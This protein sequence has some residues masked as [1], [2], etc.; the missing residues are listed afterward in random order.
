MTALAVP[1]RSSTDEHAAAYGDEHDES[2]PLCGVDA[3]KPTLFLIEEVTRYEIRAATEEEALK[4]FLE[5]PAAGRLLG[6]LDRTV[7]AA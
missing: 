1:D 4:A 2:C 3:D 7:W 6:V 5:D